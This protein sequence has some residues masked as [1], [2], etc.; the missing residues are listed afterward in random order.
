MTLIGEKT[1]PG[2][3]QQIARF[4]HDQA[5]K[6]DRCV[7]VGDVAIITGW[8]TAE[9]ILS[10]RGTFFNRS[11]R[12]EDVEQQ[13]HATGKGFIKACHLPASASTI[14]VSVKVGRQQ[15]RS[16]IEVSDAADQI[17]RLAREQQPFLAELRTLA[18]QLLPES[19]Q[20]FAQAFAIA[21]PAPEP[22]RPSDGPSQ[23]IT[24]DNQPLLAT[25]ETAAIDELIQI[26][27]HG[28]FVVGWCLQG[29]SP[30][31]SLSP[32][33]SPETRLQLS[34][35]GQPL[36]NLL[37]GAFRVSRPDLKRALGAEVSAQCES[38]GFICFVEDQRLQPSGIRVRLQTQGAEIAD[39]ALPP[40]KHFD[41]PIEGSRELLKH[42]HPGAGSALSLLERH[43]APAMTRL[44]FPTSA[45]AGQRV[46]EYGKQPEAPVLSVIIPIYGRTDF[47]ECQL[48]E[49][50]LDADFQGK[51]DLI[52]VLDD[53]RLQESF[54]HDCD[55]LSPIYPLPFRCLILDQN[56]GYSGA[57]NL[58]VGQARAEQLILLNSDVIPSQPGWAS[59]MLERFRQQA[60]CGALG[61][62]LLYPDQALQHDGMRFKRLPSLNGLWINDHPGKGL[63]AMP[64]DPAQAVV[65]VA[66]ATAACLMLRKA[67]FLA[68]GGFDEGY[69]IGDFEDSDLC[70]ALRA[71]GQQTYVARDVQL[72][73]LERQSQALFTDRSWRD[74]VSVYNCWRHARKWDPV[75]S[76]MSS[77]MNSAMSSA[78]SSA[79]AP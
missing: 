24:D 19:D 26:G 52:Y 59:A 1:L 15:Y 21:P 14:T 44:R 40:I 6:I 3:D 22:E 12:R 49:F 76:A 16:Q 63:P 70:L 48:S 10:M 39:L 38:A 28:L 29:P 27:S 53:P 33:P 73:H 35:G 36:A 67:D 30:S 60:D 56:L 37:D 61:A 7:R 51:I 46:L 4:G 54:I 57:N 45:E 66:A 11:Y 43:L 23:Q 78:T 77:A 50:A 79:E 32:S 2:L 42:L 71:Q 58:G 17:D 72:Y 62:R 25:A 69:L 20:A 9:P 74:K 13:I 68:V 34:A 31:P 75:I 8:S 47:L 5:V 64:V 18:Q 41:D 65:P 55:E